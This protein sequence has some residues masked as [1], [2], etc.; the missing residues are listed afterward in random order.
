M[1]ASWNGA[2]HRRESAI[3]SSSKATTTFPPESVKDE[4]HQT[5]LNSQSVCPW[6]GNRQLPQPG[7]QRPKQTTDAALVLILEPKDAA[8]E[9][10]GYMAFWKGVQVSE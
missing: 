8:K 6:K 9:I 5:Q 7:R 2:S 10:K 1:K 4:F 3:P